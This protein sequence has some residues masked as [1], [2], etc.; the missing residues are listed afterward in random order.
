MADIA[1]K[2]GVS[3][4]TVSLALMHSTQIPLAT[5]RRVEKLARQ[6]GY[7]KSPM[8]GELMSRLRRGD[9]DSHRMNLALVNANEAQRAFKSHPTIPSYVKGCRQRAKESGISLDVFWLHDPHL[10]GHQLVRIFH[11]RGIRGVLLVGLM[12]QNRLPSDFLP[13]IE[14]FPCVVTG[15]RT[16][17]PALS[18]VCVDHHRLVMSAFEQVL[19]KGYQRPG[20]VLDRKIDN[21][22]E[23]RFSAGYLMGQQWI[24]ARQRIRPFYD[25]TST[26]NGLVKFKRWLKRT[27]PD[28]IFT[29][30]NSTRRWLEQLGLRSPA[31]IGLVQLEWRPKHPEWAGMNQH[32]EM[33]G[34]AALDMLISKIHH[35]DRGIPAF[36]TATLIG[37]T[38]VEGETLRPDATATDSRVHC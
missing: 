26:E 11:S 37:A 28:V 4:N 34:Q 24:P 22:V 21:L 6:L 14:Q 25:L 1:R 23:G 19:K 30:Y 31:D 15:V 36:P 10:R 33:T 13:V 17:E 16:I 9:D 32:N 38:W 2:A 5:R 20:L 3:K 35:D 8:L 27:R 18:F 7:Q 12:R 29:L